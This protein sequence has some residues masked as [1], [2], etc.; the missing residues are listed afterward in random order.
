MVYVAQMTVSTHSE[1]TPK[2]CTVLQFR[3][4]RSRRIRI[5]L[6][7]DK[8]L[9]YAVLSDLLQGTVFSDQGCIHCSQ[10][11]EIVAPVA[12]PVGSRRVRSCCCCFLER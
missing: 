8:A 5:L 6:A 3:L 11:G 4:P 10:S 1:R 12:D 9:W 7:A 2:R